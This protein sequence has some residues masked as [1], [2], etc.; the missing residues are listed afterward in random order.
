MSSVLPWISG[1]DSGERFADSARRPG[2]R[3]K[4]SPTRRRFIGPTWALWSEA[5]NLTLANIEK[6]ADA[7]DLRMWQLLKEMEEG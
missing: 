1:S 5:T 6:L 3:R 4:H 2:T 7:F